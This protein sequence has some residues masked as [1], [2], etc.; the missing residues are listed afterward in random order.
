MIMNQLSFKASCEYYKR[1]KRYSKL[2]DIDLSRIDLDDNILPEADELVDKLQKD[3]VKERTATRKKN[4]RV[5][6][7][8]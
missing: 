3:I 6:L 8:A 1:S 4:L 2:Y 5:E 7:N